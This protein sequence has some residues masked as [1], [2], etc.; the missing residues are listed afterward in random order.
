MVKT[1]VCC[2][3]PDALDLISNQPRAHVYIS[4]YIGNIICTICVR[5]SRTACPAIAAWTVPSK[6]FNI[7]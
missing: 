2:L 1:S 4:Y 3:L 6:L 5:E 7:I